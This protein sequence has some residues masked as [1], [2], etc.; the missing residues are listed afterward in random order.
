M[1]KSLTVYVDAMKLATK[2]QNIDPMWKVPEKEVDLGEPTSLH[3]LLIWR[4]MQRNVWND[5]VSWQNKTT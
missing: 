2:K 4:V 5:F 1:G 3:G